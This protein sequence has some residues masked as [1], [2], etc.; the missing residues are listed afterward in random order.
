MVEQHLNTRALCVFVVGKI[1]KVF[2]VSTPINLLL[3]SIW[4]YYVKSRGWSLSGCGW[5]VY[6]HTAS[7]CLSPSMWTSIWCCRNWY[8]QAARMCGTQWLTAKLMLTQ[9][10]Y[11]FCTETFNATSLHAPY[12]Q[13][14]I[15]G[16]IL[17]RI[18]KCRQ[19]FL[20]QCY[21][22]LIISKCKVTVAYGQLLY[23]VL[24]WHCITIPRYLLWYASHA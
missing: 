24:K 4:L 16:I 2:T 21:L 3:V 14:H 12:T 6:F 23:E 11:E 13:N 5:R 20:I 18:F 1:P 7:I 9:W 19:K 10:T 15:F 8:K 22:W 17:C